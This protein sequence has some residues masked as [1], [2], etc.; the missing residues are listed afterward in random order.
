M[1][2]SL[3]SSEMKD[4]LWSELEL[5]SVLHVQY[6][7]VMYSRHRLQTWDRFIRRETDTF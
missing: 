5:W 6:V 3:I 2:W 1:I 4:D 7:M